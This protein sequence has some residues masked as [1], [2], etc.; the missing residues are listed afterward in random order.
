MAAILSLGAPAQ[1]EWPGQFAVG[2]HDDSVKAEG[3]FVLKRFQDRG[4][5]RREVEFLETAASHPFLSRYVPRFSEY[6]AGGEEDA[7]PGWI[8]MENLLFDMVE[9]MVMDVKMGTTLHG[10]D[11]TEE[12]KRDMINK[13]LKLRT[14]RLGVRITC[15]RMPLSSSTQPHDIIFHKYKRAAGPGR[16]ECHWPQ[17][18][19]IKFIFF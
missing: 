15:Y 12:K 13:A 16:S 9:P 17:R 7:D 1:K 14:Y 3:P 2:G 6:R 10:F 11:A 4:R 8:V 18:S 5:G 19:G